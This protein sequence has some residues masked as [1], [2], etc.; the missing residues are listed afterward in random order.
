MKNAELLF[1][2]MIKCNIL[3]VNFIRYH[4]TAHKERVIEIIKIN[5]F[6]NFKVIAERNKKFLNADTYLCP[7]ILSKIVS[8]LKNN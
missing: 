5:N 6:E 4:L 2:Y 8:Y 1:L 7:K 3:I